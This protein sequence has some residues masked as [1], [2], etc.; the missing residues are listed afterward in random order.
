MPVGELLERTTSAELG[1]W[2]AFEKAYGPLGS[3]Y[4]EHRLADILDAVQSLEWTV[5]CVNTTEDERDEADVS[6]PLP[7]RRP[8]DIAPV[9][10]DEEADGEDEEQVEY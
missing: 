10:E 3:S 1:E 8:A 2:Q 6:I 7:T 9:D 5:L 4:A